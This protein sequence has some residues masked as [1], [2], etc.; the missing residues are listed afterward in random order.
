MAGACGEEPSQLVRA[1]GVVED[2]QPTA[3]PAQ[4][5]EQPGRCLPRRVGRRGE[6][7]GLG[8]LRHLLA[9]QLRVL[10]CDPP[11]DVVVVAVAV[12]ELDHRGCD[13][14]PGAALA[15]RQHDRPALAQ[16]PPDR[17]EQWFPVDHRLAAGRDV[18]RPMLER[19]GGRRS[20]RP[21]LVARG[22]GLLV[23]WR[24]GWRP[25]PLAGDQVHAC[26]QGHRSEDERRDDH[27]EGVAGSRLGLRRDHRV[28]G[29][30]AVRCRDAHDRGARQVAG[31]GQREQVTAAQ[32]GGQPVGQEGPGP[33]GLALPVCGDGEG[34]RR[35]RGR[36][37]VPRVDDQ[38][39]LPVRRAGR[40]HPDR[41]LCP[42]D[43]SA[44]ELQEDQQGRQHNPSQAA[45]TRWGWHRR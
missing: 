34:L 26:Q 39:S 17:R 38:P 32:G 7:D 3:P 1:L 16:R 44:A 43:R 24:L 14:H 15:G 9:D 25:P 30:G 5:V 12:R 37:G 21:R 29:E 41:L 11:D 27:G 36:G 42:T 2:Q 23:G 31:H 6:P 35:Q 19:V 40:H 22:F 18:P 28:G 4:R 45:A 10:R 8:Q 13:T 20:G 33:G